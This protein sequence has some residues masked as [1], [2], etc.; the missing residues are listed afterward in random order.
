[1]LLRI[2]AGLVCE[3]ELGDEEAEVDAEVVAPLSVCKGDI[4]GPDAT[5]VLIACGICRPDMLILL[6]ATAAFAGDADADEEADDGT[7]NPTGVPSS[8]V[9][10]ED[11]AN[12]SSGRITRI[13][14]CILRLAGREAQASNRRRRRK[15]REGSKSKGSSTAVYGNVTAQRQELVGA[16]RVES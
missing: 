6:G 12:P 11:G 5:F 9:E 15:R 13:R 2:D 14:G 8:G 16:T 4:P 10:M 7:N 3:L 1:L